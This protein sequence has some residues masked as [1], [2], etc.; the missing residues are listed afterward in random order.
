MIDRAYVDEV[1]SQAFK[2]VDHRTPGDLRGPYEVK[3]A[4]ITH[5]AEDALVEGMQDTA[6]ALLRVA[7]VYATLNVSDELT[8]YHATKGEIRR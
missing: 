7:Q 3:A 8:R 6:D 2:D 1:F 4:T 5:Y